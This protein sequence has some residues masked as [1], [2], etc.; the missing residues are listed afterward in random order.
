[1]D[2]SVCIKEICQYYGQQYDNV[3]HMTYFLKSLRE[4][5]NAEVTN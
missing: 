2:K 4:R 1:M 3:K 5:Y